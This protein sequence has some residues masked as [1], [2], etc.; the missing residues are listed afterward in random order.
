MYCYATTNDCYGKLV[1][2]FETKEQRAKWLECQNAMAYSDYHQAYFANSSNDWEIALRKDID[3]LIR[4][5]EKAPHS[6]W[7]GIW[8]QKHLKDEDIEAYGEVLNP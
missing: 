2:R 6:V 1:A 4:K 8:I 5:A 7:D 3:D